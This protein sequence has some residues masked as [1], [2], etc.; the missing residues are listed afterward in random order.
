MVKA[1]S[2][3]DRGVAYIPLDYGFAA[4]SQTVCPDH[5][6]YDPSG[7]HWG[8]YDDAKFLGSNQYG[9]TFI[10]AVTDSSDGCQLRQAFTSR[11]QNVS[12]RVFNC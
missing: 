2:R 11:S 12:S 7:G 5:R 9:Y 1:H 3:L 6:N 10:S 8:D 4:A